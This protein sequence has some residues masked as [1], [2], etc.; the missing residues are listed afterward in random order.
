MYH[1]TKLPSQGLIPKGADSIWLAESREAPHLPHFTLN[2][3]MVAPAGP[4]P[5]AAA[6]V[7][8][9]RFLLIDQAGTLGYAP[10]VPDF[11]SSFPHRQ[12]HTLSG[13]SGNTTPWQLHRLHDCVTASAHIDCLTAS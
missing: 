9:V 8:L 1:T 4:G 10:E 13:V 6:A 5:E 7:K 12:R 11:P 3:A 2:Q